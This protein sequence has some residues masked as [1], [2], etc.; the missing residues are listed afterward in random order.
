MLGEFEEDI[1][2]QVMTLIEQMIRKSTWDTN[3]NIAELKKEMQ[4]MNAQHRKN[5]NLL[6]RHRQS[7]GDEKHN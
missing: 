6:K 1:S 4:N 2:N 7:P 5:G 3:K